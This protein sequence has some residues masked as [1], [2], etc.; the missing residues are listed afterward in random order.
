MVLSSSD[1]VLVAS[2]IDVPRPGAAVPPKSDAR[3]VTADMAW[4]QHV[5]KVQVRIG[6]GDRAEAELS[7]ELTADTWRQ[8]RCEHTGLSA[9]THTVSAPRIRSG[10]KRAGLETPARHS[11]CR[12][13]TP[14]A[15]VNRRVGRAAE[16]TGSSGQ[17]P[18]HTVVPRVPPC[19]LAAAVSGFSR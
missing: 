4:A 18:G 15:P 5:E 19:E 3:V 16:R 12:D 9:G 2:R 11:G 14:R 1:D 10:R 6:N 8:W 13:G 17:Q 7:E